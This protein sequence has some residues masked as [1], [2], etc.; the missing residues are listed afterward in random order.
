MNRILNDKTKVFQ[1]K[2]A[3]VFF[4]CA[5]K[6]GNVEAMVSYSDILWNNHRETNAL[7]WLSRA[8]NE[9]EVARERT[10]FS[11]SCSTTPF[12][13]QKELLSV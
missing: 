6:K 13:L 8:S 1:K 5:S 11:I 7:K 12:K 9:S 4:E 10:A 2:D 3:E